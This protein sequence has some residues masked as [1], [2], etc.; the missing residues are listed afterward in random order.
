MER[1]QASRPDWR[2][3]EAYAS[4]LAAERPMLAWEW[5]RRIPAYRHAWLGAEQGA[6]GAA[7][8]WGLHRFEDPAIPVPYARPIWTAAALGPVLA[9]SAIP[10]ASAAASGMD[11]WSGFLTIEASDGAE[12]VLLTDGWRMIRIDIAEGTVS[13]GPVKLRFWIDGPPT[14]AVLLPPLRRFDALVR[15]GRFVKA[16]HPA[17]PRI[18]RLV[19]VLRTADALTAGAGQREIAAFVLGGHVDGRGWREDHAHLRLQAQRL[20]RDARMYRSG[21]YRALLSMP[22][23]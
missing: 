15:Q 19:R 5:L 9:A 6:K 13:N 17:E 16:L 4:L 11:A 20:V 21:G 3:A 23:G 22:A 8:Q 10:D 18:S 2:D 7:N 1:G 14:L 12:H